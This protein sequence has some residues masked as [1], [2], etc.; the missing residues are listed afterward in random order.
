MSAMTVAIETAELVDRFLDDAA[1]CLHDDRLPE[2]AV[3]EHWATELTRLA[4]HPAFAMA[5]DVA[6]TG[7]ATMD[8]LGHHPST[9]ATLYLASDPPG[10][11]GPAH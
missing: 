10:T 8:E 2:R 4:L 9:Q 5:H 3:L 7:G 11:T 1:R 6:D